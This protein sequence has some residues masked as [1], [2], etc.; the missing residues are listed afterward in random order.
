MVF[1]DADKMGP[2]ALRCVIA[3]VNVAKSW[4]VFIAEMPDQTVGPILGVA[5]RQDKS[6]V[7]IGRIDFAIEQTPRVIL[8]A[9][10]G[11]GQRQGDVG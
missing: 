11:L 8:E 4:V 5:P 9:G 6:S 2:A 3:S 1:I 10:I 7:R